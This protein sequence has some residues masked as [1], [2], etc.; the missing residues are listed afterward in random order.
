[1]FSNLQKTATGYSHIHIILQYKVQRTLSKRKRDFKEEE[2]FQRGRYTLQYN[3][4]PSLH[5]QL[6]IHHKP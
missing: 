1:M 3:E 2:I 6:K 5:N 4:K